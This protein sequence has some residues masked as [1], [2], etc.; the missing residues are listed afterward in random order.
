MDVF[1]ELTER[2]DRIAV[3]F[4]YDRVIKD[5]VKDV[6]GARF[7]QK[8]TTNSTPHWTLPLDLLSARILRKQFGD[9]LVLGDAVKAW[10]RAAVQQERKL[11]SMA[12][13][14]D[15]DLSKLKVTK[16]LPALAE[17][18][19]SHRAYQ[20]ADIKFLA[21]TNALNL[22]EPRLGKTIEIIAALHEADL[23]KGPH[24][25]VAPQKACESIWKMEWERWTKIP[26]FVWNGEITNGERRETLRDIERLLSGGKP[27]VLATTADMIRR[28]LPDGLEM[29]IQWNSFTI[30]EFHKTGLPEVKN[31]FPKKAANIHAE[32]KY[33]MSGTPMGG[34]PIKLWG[35]LNWLEPNRYTSKWRWAGQWLT[36]SEGYQ[37]HKVI[38]GIKKG[39]EDEFYK[40]LAPHVVRRLRV[41]VL[42]ELPPKQ[43]VDVWCTMTTKQA[44]QYKEF[45]R[46]AEIRIDEYHL[47]A[48]SILAEY[49]RLKQFANARCEVEVFGVDEETGA[50]DMKVKPTFD[51]GK[52][53]YLMERLA[54]AGIDPDEPEGTSQA[55]VASQ[56]AEVVNM[57]YDYLTS[58]GIPCIKVTGKVKRA[59]SARAQRTFKADADH[60]GLR[61]MCMTTTLG[62][63]ITLD[64]VETV[65]MLDET[66]NP[67]DQ[68]QLSDRAI[69]TT[70][71]HQVT[72]FT[73]RS[74]GTVE[75]Y[76]ADVT[77]EKAEI[78]REIL[79]RRR[80]KFRA[81]M[82]A[83]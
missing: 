51:S 55:I 42:P 21:S 39:L 29:A 13:L 28:G 23:E 15:F 56:F 43:P 62:V 1:A 27:F 22:N 53:P 59:D 36:I 83:A 72:V 74:R 73:Y 8:S 63:A 16:K 34:K 32:R 18:F 30:D 10:G 9:G 67:D 38:G 47:S 68:E 25:V 3:Y 65:H 31:R 4:H 6:P 54:E 69:N 82:K 66:W 81:A 77:A 78:N 41:E 26:A 19:L 7:V 33:A 11:Q 24:L 20:R 17:Q 12:A 70:R 45:A 37:N 76:I 80:K 44:A 57:A 5:K 52:L 61:V 48:T 40:A 14:D 50:V 60:E 49:T 46:A 2:G 64:N 58:K 71:N 79:D 75:E 35:A